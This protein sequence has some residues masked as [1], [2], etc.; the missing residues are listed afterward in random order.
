MNAMEQPRIEWEGTM[1]RLSADEFAAELRERI[2]EYE[3]RHGCS[4]A[5]KLASL[6]GGRYDESAE[7]AF[8]MC[9]Y[10]ALLMLEADSALTAGSLTTVA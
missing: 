2:A 9:D 6:G 1:R 7:V 3:R 4:S 5:E 10:Q 8:W